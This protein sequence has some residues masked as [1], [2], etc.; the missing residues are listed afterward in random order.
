[1]PDLVEDILDPEELE[2]RTAW[3]KRLSLPVLVSLD[4][5]FKE[6][7]IQ[8]TIL[9]GEF[10][11]KINPESYRLEDDKTVPQIRFLN[12]PE[13][14]LTKLVDKIENTDQFYPAVCLLVDGTGKR[15]DLPD[16]ILP[17]EQFVIN[18]SVYGEINEFISHLKALVKIPFTTKGIGMVGKDQDFGFSEVNPFYI[19]VCAF[20]DE[21]LRKFMDEILK[22]DFY[23]K[24][25]LKVV[26]FLAPKAG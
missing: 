15:N 14:D 13:A 17:V 22:T 1:M 19:F 25:L 3:N 18:R 12:H 6:N 7:N 4:N 2:K 26:G 23:Q 11:Q 8:K 21:D 5:Y 24:H 16:N 9:S 20:N 10:V